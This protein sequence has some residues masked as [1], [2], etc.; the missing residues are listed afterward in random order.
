MPPF[1]ESPK[2]LSPFQGNLFSVHCLD[3]QAEDR[4]IHSGTWDSLWES[5]EG[6]PR[7]KASRESHRSLDPRE[8]KRDTAAT[9]REESARACPHSGRGQTP[10]GRLQKYP[11]IHV[12]TGEESS[13]SGTVSTLGLRPRHR[14]ERNPERPQS[15]SHGDWPFLRPPERIP[16]VPVGSREHMPQHERIQEVLPSRRDEAHFP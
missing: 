5:L 3:F 10:L 6:K 16:G 4:L 15:N 7:G 12:S 1:P 9:A 13:G 11:K 14:R 8:G 2:Y